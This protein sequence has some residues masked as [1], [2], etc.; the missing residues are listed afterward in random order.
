[1]KITL[2]LNHTALIEDDRKPTVTVS[3]PYA[4]TLTVE[5]IDY[6]IAP[7]GTPTPRITGVIGYVKAFYTD[8]LGIRYPVINP[9]IKNETVCSM[10]DFSKGYFE[11]V[12]YVD[13]LAREIEQL[14]QELL[15]L[16][17]QIE[18]DA[19]GHIIDGGNNSE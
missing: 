15:D 12:G 18:P 7:E 17:A 9:H 6:P 19:L 11:M 4:G 14:T 8:S 10:V 5:G 3:P 1:M 13:T 16:R 2:L